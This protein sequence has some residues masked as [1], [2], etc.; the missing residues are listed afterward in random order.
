MPVLRVRS[1]GPE[2]LQFVG[3]IGG[4]LRAALEWADL[5]HHHDLR[6]GLDLR[7]RVPELRSKPS[8]LSTHGLIFHTGRY[9]AIKRLA[10][11]A[12]YL[13]TLR[14]LDA[15]VASSET[16][17][18]AVASLPNVRVLENPVEVEPFLQL[19]A[20]RHRP[21]G[22]LLYFGRLARNKAIERLADA[23]RLDRALQLVVV[24]SGASRDLRRLRREFGG[25]PARFTGGLEQASLLEEIQASSVI[26]LPSL[27]EGFGITLVEAMAT[28]R[29]VVA[30][31]IAPYR[32][33]STGT[34]VRLV[35]FG[36]SPAVVAAVRSA[37]KTYDRTRAI[38]RVRSLSW[39]SRAPAFAS[40]YQDLVG[41]AHRERGRGPLTGHD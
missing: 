32:S 38:D 37:R 16:D 11:W 33:I 4:E 27:A 14:S 41:R 22:P 13:P 19:A 40:L 12:V 36:D 7:R 28:G 20:S 10:W 15:V 23:L 1:F 3:R 2:R 8:L 25:L 9:R 5:V 17:L 21:D 26:V 29:P 31:D 24:G 39:A 35:D 6:F 30:A 18:D 34:D